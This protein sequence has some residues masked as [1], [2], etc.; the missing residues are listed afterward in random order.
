MKKKLGGE[1]NASLGHKKLKLRNNEF[2]SYNK[3]IKRKRKMKYG[4]GVTADS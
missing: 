4:N 2:I 3:Q 1:L